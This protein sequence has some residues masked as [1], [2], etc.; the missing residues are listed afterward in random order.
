MA[1][2]HPASLAEERQE[3]EKYLRRN[4]S[5]HALEGGLFI[6][7]VAFVHPQTV[8]PRMIEKLGGPDWV[9]A[10]SPILLMVGFFLPS[11]FITHR[12]ERLSFLKPFVMRIGALQR[13]PYLLVGA[14]LW[15]VSGAGDA[16]LPLVVLAPLLSGLAGGVS[17]T[18]WREYV[19][20]SI[21][22]ERRASL[23]AVRFVLGGV[24]GVLAGRVVTWALSHY[25]P[26]AAYGV[27]HLGVFV[28]MAGSFIVF[29]F[30]REPNLDSHRPHAE[31]NWWSYARSMRRAVREDTR[32]RLY[33][34]CRLLIS[35]IYVVLPFLA[36]HA[37]DVLHK[38][39][40]YLG[41]LLTCQMLGSVLG[42]VAGGYVGDRQ[43]GKR[44]TLLSLAGSAAVPLAA[45][46][47][48]TDLGFEL[49]F[50]GLGLS[51][52]LGA[53]GVPTLDLELS[54]F[55]QRMSYQT[56]IGFS[57]LLGMLGAVAAASFVRQETESF[58]VLAS[59][60]A[61]TTLASLCLLV[62]LPEPRRGAG[63]TQ[64]GPATTAGESGAR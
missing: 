56:L 20:K 45:I 29:A 10:A 55:A 27:L 7:G 17:V 19:A 21:P 52:G 49:L 42:N 34:P 50:V 33:L 38:P 36:L 58:D 1:A 24:I 8:L 37:L 14:T 54:G 46:W 15:F 44:I 48:H 12:L 53:V 59:I 60:A 2:P 9:I 57:H 51:L 40:G 41:R 18:A 26:I 16:V 11:L 47:M 6:G 23:W 28:F 5:A 30:T 63:A 61:A 64:P 4:Y 22:P 25:P 39:D 62:G 31:T 3:V 35:G 43:G 32:L 13:L